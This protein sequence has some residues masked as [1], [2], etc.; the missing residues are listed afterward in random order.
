MSRNIF[1]SV[2]VQKPKRSFFDLSHS[3]MTTMDMGNLIPICYIN[4]MPGDS[5]TI[6]GRTQLTFAPMIAPNMTPVN[7]YTHYWFVPYRLLW[8][9]WEKFITHDNSNTDLPLMPNFSYGV[10]GDIDPNAKGLHNYFGLPSL[11]VNTQAYFLNAFYPA[12]YQKIWNDYYRDENLQVDINPPGTFILTDGTQT[13]LN[14]QSIFTL[15]KRAWMHDQFTGALP[16]AQKGVAVSLPVDVGDLKVFANASSGLYTTLDGTPNDISVPG[17]P[18]TN[19]DVGAGGLYA[20]GGAAT[21]TLINDLRTAIA[22]QQFLE[23][24]ARGGTRY[25]ELVREHFG[26]TPA[27]ARL[28]RAEYIGGSKSP[29]I[30]S[31]VLNTAGSFDPSDPTLA[32]SPPQGNMSGHGKAYNVGK[33]SKYF[34]QEHGCIIGLMSVMPVTMYSQGIHRVWRMADHIEDFAWP[35]FANLGEQTVPTDEVFADWDHVANPDKELW[36]YNP[37]YY[38]YKYMP[39][40]V[41]GDFQASLNFWTLGREFSSAAIPQLNEEFIECDA[42]KRIFAVQDPNVNSLYVQHFNDVKVVRCLPKYGAPGLLRL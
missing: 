19:T 14:A 22:T 42:S 38:A 8:A 41:T 39:S 10:G 18:S 25:S 26:V 6:G 20:Q 13:T 33:Y 28:Q 17:T 34:T 2:P 21:N 4:C 9:N 31:E 29:V 30:V 40:L 5:F 3:H 7:L 16:F 32:G 23:K 15:R 36:G 37:R 11:Q 1:N 27:D 24:N 12:A 35:V